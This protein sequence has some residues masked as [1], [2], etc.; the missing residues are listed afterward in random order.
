M[1]V[2]N[3]YDMTA[4]YDDNG[5][6][7]TLTREDD[8]NQ[9]DNLGYH[10]LAGTNKLAGVDDSSPNEGGFG[11]GGINSANGAMTE[12]GYDEMGNT[13]FDLNKEIVEINYNQF[14]YVESIVFA[15]DTEITYTYDA[16][17][18]KLQ[19][20]IWDADGTEIAIV[21]YVGMVEYLNGEINQ[22]STKEGRAYR[23]GNS[24]SGR[25]AYFYEYFITDHQGN[26]RVAFGVLP[27]RK[28]HL[29]TL[30]NVDSNGQEDG[31]EIPANVAQFVENHTPLGARSAALNAVAGRMVG[32]AMVLDI[33]SGDHVEMEDWAK[34]TDFNWQADAT[35][36][37]AAAVVSAF[38]NSALGSVGEAVDALNETIGAA[39]GLSTMFS[40]TANNSEPD[41][42]LQYIFFDKS[43]TYVQSGFKGVGNGAFDKYERLE[44][45]G[46]FDALEDGYLYIYVANETA[47]DQEVYFDDIKVTHESALANFKVSQVNEYYPYGLPTANS[48]RNEGYIDPGLLYQ[49]SFA[50]YDSLTGYYDFLSRSYDPATGRFFAVDPA[51]QFSSPYVGMGNM[52]HWGVDPNGEFFHGILKAIG[53]F[54]WGG[55]KN[56]WEQNVVNAGVN[57]AM[58]GDGFSL[59]LVNTFELGSS[60]FQLY[61]DKATWRGQ[62]R[63][64]RNKDYW[65][66]ERREFN[67][68][69]AYLLAGV[70]INDSY[71]YSKFNFIQTVESNSNKRGDWRTK[72][73]PYLVIDGLPSGT[74]YEG[75]DIVGEIGD[76]LFP[77]LYINADGDDPP[78]KRN[79]VLLGSRNGNTV[80]R[81]F[82]TPERKLVGNGFKMNGQYW[83]A[84]TSVMGLT[85]L[86][87]R[88]VRIS[89]IRWGFSII[90]GGVKL[91]NPRLVTPNKFHNGALYFANRIPNVRK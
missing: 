50:S 16:S 30:E 46:G 69:G 11:E 37:I 38:S 34:F 78:N 19:K 65:N 45:I 8:E 91:L 2:T 83:K 84:E 87:K 77:L 32:P 43:Y 18:L 89:T 1:A 5:N 24:P 15:D 64:Y 90:D 54:I 81:F 47:L 26:N 63:T 52:P 55:I 39:E 35:G 28:I 27:Y 82:D 44:I 79:L 14:Q 58:G 72:D 10:Y 48:W 62:F 3:A 25:G 56:N 61:D 60:N 29:A 70:E 12:F 4:S 20:I 80:V 42:Y 40:E 67:R 75:T 86:S 53:S 68:Q 6:L 88:W 17:G 23:Q 85:R 13:T 9:L 31:F 49:S 76:D 51:G 74:E 22:I 71:L 33:K 7:E 57:F 41:A 21:D 73:N 59:G 66:S 36:D